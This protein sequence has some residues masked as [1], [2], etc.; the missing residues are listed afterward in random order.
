MG[1][2]LCVGCTHPKCSSF[3]SC[4]FWGIAMVMFITWYSSKS[5][6]PLVVVPIVL[7]GGPSC[8][9]HV[10]SRC[11]TRGPVE[12]YG[13]FFHVCLMVTHT[14]IPVQRRDTLHFYQCDS[15]EFSIWC[16]FLAD[17][18][19]WFPLKGPY[20]YYLKL[21]WNA[22]HAESAS[23]LTCR[24]VTTNIIFIRPT[25]CPQPS[26]PFYAKKCSYIQQ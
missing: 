12:V 1:F 24:F 15:C 11:P 22:K 7:S 6:W 18:C 5:R 17:S 20:L 16:S 10:V 8:Y 26:Q 4:G 25:I 14:T 21:E 3:A 9:V 19:M 2:W 13:F 23:G